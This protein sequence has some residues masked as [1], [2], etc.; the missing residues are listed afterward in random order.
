M[1]L[2]RRSDEASTTTGFDR[3]L[4]A[5][6]VLGSVLNPVNSSII[7]VSL[8]PIGRDLGATPAGTAWLITA[9]YLATAV[10]QPVV[11]RLVDLLGP[12][13]LYLVGTAMVGLGGLLGL[14]APDLGWLVVARVV[15]GLGTCAGY[16][17]AMHLV[18]REA[19]RTGESSPAG[20]L[21]TLAVANQTVAVIGPTLGG[22]LIGLGGWRTT[23]AVNLPLAAACLLL[24][25]RRLPRTT[26]R[27]SGPVVPA[28][29]LPGIALFAGALVALL[30][31]LGGP[32][33][34]TAWLPVLAVVLAAGFVAVELRAADPFVDLRLLRGNRSLVLTFVRAGLAATVSYV[35]L[36]GFT[37]WLE[38]G[39]GFSPTGAGL[40]LLPMFAAAI[41]VSLLTGRRP[42]VWGKLVVGG[43]GQ[44]AAACLMLLL[45]A[46][47]SVALLVAVVLVLGLPQG[48][49]SLANQNAV[50][51]QADDGRTASSAG[52][53]R[54]FSY[55]GAIVAGTANGVLL[56]P[57]AGTAGLHALAVF[58]GVVALL[59]TALTLLDRPLRRVGRP[60]SAP[61]TT[62][63][64]TQEA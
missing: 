43:L 2:H 35:V 64:T 5:P 22:L 37:Q 51:H 60:P 7:A 16:P 4:L 56:G 15:L 47:S 57:S 8:V 44:L 58:S 12:R 49:L 63:T 40:V 46:T 13:P 31:W 50:F 55:L 1:P 24:G 20:V 45:G 25:A 39:R 34:A 27:R 48:L 19:D 59:M 28:L 53:L 32:S 10:G 38:E 6:M 61:T 23:F 36:Y 14:L 52:L 26:P 62:P 11:G 30:V 33:A 42:Q 29:D 18:R 41:V 54:T 21:T 17:S 3:R 9:L